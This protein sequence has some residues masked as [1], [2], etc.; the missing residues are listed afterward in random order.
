[1]KWEHRNLQ[2]RTVPTI[3]MWSKIAQKDLDQL[4]ELQNSGWE[5]FQVVNIRGSVG[6]TSHVLFMLRREVLQ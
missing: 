5:V 3:G 1:M 4:T 2:F 6:F